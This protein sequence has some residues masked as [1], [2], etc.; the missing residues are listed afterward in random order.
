M[1]HNIRIPR[2][3]VFEGGSTARK[4]LNGLVLRFQ[5]TLDCSLSG[6]NFG[7]QSHRQ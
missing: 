7:T 5:M 2:H 3:K 1:C 4:N 6:Q